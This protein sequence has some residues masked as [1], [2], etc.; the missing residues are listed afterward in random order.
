MTALA[1]RADVVAAIG[2]AVLLSITDRDGNDAE[3]TGIVD[4]ALDDASSLV[5]SFVTVPATV[6][7][8]LRRA[9]IDIA[10]WKLRIGHDMLTADSKL[11]Y[12]EA[13]KWLRELAAGEAVIPV[14]IDDGAEASSSNTIECYADT[15]LWGNP[16]NGC[17][18]GMF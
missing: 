18:R 5:T 14:V 3:D 17:T 16:P 15:R 7:E 12:D 11:A 8:A 2:A 9:T 4:A 13:M 10:V 1:T 6:P